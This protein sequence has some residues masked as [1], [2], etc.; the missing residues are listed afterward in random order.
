MHEI[1]AALSTL[2]ILK[3]LTKT[4]IDSKRLIA[5]RKQAIE[6]QAAII[7]LQNTMIGMQSQYQALLQEKDQLK[8]QLAEIERWETEAD[9]YYLEQIEPGVFAYAL[10]PDM[11]PNEPE[12]WLCTQY[13]NKQKSIL[14]RT[15]ADTKGIVYLCFRCQN[16]IRVHRNPGTPQT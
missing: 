9:K 1:P 14:V 8:K 6:S 5:V 16:S 15:G 3:D 7:E 2:K 12:H 13:E 11:E 10:D 4:I